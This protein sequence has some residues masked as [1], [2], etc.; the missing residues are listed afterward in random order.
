[1]LSC[2]FLP[3]IHSKLSLRLPFVL[4]RFIQIGRVLI[5][6]KKMIFLL[7]QVILIGSHWLDLPR[8]DT[9][10]FPT[11]HKVDPVSFLSLIKHNLVPNKRFLDE[12]IG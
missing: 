3:D 6:A 1:M 10:K 9:F 2:I 5:R 11:F 7:A 8:S 12:R 4:V